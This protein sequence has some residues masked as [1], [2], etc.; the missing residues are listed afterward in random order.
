MTDE[1]V[2]KLVL[3]ELEPDCTELDSVKLFP[4]QPTVQITLNNGISYRE[5]QRLSKKFGTEDMLIIRS[6]DKRTTIVEL[7]D[8]S[9]VVSN[10][11]K[12][13]QGEF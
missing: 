13:F 3:E 7:F 11:K 10:Q 9:K 5:L 8:C 2:F 1:E 12:E 6:D 4:S